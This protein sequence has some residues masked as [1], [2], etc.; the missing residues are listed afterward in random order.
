M[1]R[2]RILMHFIHQNLNSVR[3]GELADA[4]AKIEDVAALTNRP[5]F[6]QKPTNFR[7]NGVLSSKKNRGIHVAL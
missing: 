7:T 6:I 1:L 2:S 5:E 3:I 4:V